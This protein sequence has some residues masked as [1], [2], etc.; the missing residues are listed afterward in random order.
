MGSQPAVT[1]SG[2][3]QRASRPYGRLFGCGGG[4]RS[5]EQ[6]V[7]AAPSH[8]GS[9]GSRNNVDKRGLAS[10]AGLG[11]MAQITR[12]GLRDRGDLRRRQ[13]RVT[14]SPQAD[15]WQRSY[16]HGNGDRRR[17]WCGTNSFYRIS[18]GSG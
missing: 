6:R 10:T 9:L 2:A 11:W 17:V 5:G 14:D 12:V 18:T 15:A 8:R 16:D 3:G 4:S 13:S 7:S 1:G